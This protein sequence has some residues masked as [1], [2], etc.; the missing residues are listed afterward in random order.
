MAWK[1][2]GVQ[3]PLA[4]RRTV[5]QGPN[6][7]FA[8]K[9]S[10]TFEAETADPA[11]TGDHRFFEETADGECLD[12]LRRRLHSEFW[13]VPDQVHDEIIDQLEAEFGAK[14]R[15]LDTTE[16]LE[17]YLGTDVFILLS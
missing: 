5:R 13:R 9:F 7:G 2:S 11:R 10:L 4:P 16:R 17:P 6:T 1:R 15:G 3:F 14:P 8:V 12:H